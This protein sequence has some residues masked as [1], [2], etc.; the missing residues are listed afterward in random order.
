MFS[1]RMHEI[2]NDMLPFGFIDDGRDEP[3]V[4]PDDP[5]GVIQPEVW[6]DYR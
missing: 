4:Q 6:H 1:Q 3:L 5:W 2:E